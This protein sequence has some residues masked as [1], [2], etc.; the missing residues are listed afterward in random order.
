MKAKLLTRAAIA[1]VIA[2]SMTTALASQPPEL[3]TA[4]DIPPGIAIP[5]EMDTRLGKL[6]FVDGA[7]S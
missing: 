3:K 6:T 5:D 4:A 7:P 2:A 1:A